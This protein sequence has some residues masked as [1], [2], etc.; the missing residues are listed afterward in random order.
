MK[1]IYRLLEEYEHRLTKY[2]YCLPEESEHRRTK[3][4]YTGCRRSTNN[5]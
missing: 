1:Y 3:Y 2:I 5:A 4:I